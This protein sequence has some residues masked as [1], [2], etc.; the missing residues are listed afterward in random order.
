MAEKQESQ[1]TNT[2]EAKFDKLKD[3]LKEKKEE[4]DAKLSNTEIKSKS[5]E[6]FKLGYFIMKHTERG[7]KNQKLLTDMEK[8]Y[9]KAEY[10]RFKR[11]DMDLNQ[12]M[13]LTEQTLKFPLY[14]IVE[15]QD[16][17]LKQNFKGKTSGF[18]DDIPTKQHQKMYLLHVDPID[19]MRVW[20][21]FTNYRLLTDSGKEW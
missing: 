5:T 7:G 4:E 11:K 17:F 14:I 13:P 6:L 19:S 21:S 10:H 1:Q 12:I 2:N 15:K 3:K 16:N 8:E 9:E 20:C 18:K